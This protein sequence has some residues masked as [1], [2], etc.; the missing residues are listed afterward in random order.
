MRPEPRALQ[1]QRS[2]ETTADDAPAQVYVSLLGVL[3]AYRKLHLG[4]ALLRRVLRACQAATADAGTESVA[5]GGGGDGSAAGGAG[6]VGEVFVHVQASNAPA[7]A[8]YRKL[9]FAQAGVEL[10][11]FYP[12]VESGSEAALLLRCVPD[13]VG[14]I[15][16]AAAQAQAQ[17]QAQTQAQAQP[18]AQAQ[19]QA[20][21]PAPAGGAAAA[22]AAASV[23]AA[24][25]VALAQASRGD[26]T[27]KR[28][29]SVAE[30]EGEGGAASNNARGSKSRRTHSGSGT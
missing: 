28:R 5:G 26:A 12:R 3:P 10:P 4:T 18:Q 11:R 24:G 29:R 20:Q 2:E 27:A 19:A 23:A 22:A 13:D 6:C 17:A 1:A 21:A 15:N 9:G 30:E 7:I 25:G 14:V 8:L 16:A